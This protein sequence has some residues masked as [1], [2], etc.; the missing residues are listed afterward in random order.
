MLN[1]KIVILVVEDELPMLEALAIK[2]ND[3]GYKVFKAMD[4]EQGLALAN[5]H[6]PDLIII[7]I[8]LPKKDGLSMMRDLRQ[9]AWGKQTPMILLTN[10]V[11]D[12]AMDKQILEL[13]PAYYL[14]K[15][16]WSLEKVMEK[17]EQAL[18]K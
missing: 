3:R 6:H 8:L 13:Q 14:E 2:L 12:D 7:D 4:G 1:D 17:V 11:A 9:T 16:A 10:V 18:K 15:A 5:R